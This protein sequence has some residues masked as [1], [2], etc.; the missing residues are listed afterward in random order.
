MTYCRGCGAL[1]PEG[2]KFCPECGAP[3]LKEPERIAAPQIRFPASGRRNRGKS[4]F[5]RWWF[6]VLLLAAIGSLHSRGGQDEPEPASPA[7]RQTEVRAT[8]APTARPTQKP[9]PAPTARPTQ[10][11]SPA[12]TATPTPAPAVDEQVIRPEIREFLDAYEA[13][14]NEYVTFMQKYL[15]DPMNAV[16][17]LGDYYRIL[18]R[19]IEFSDK[20]DAMDVDELTDAELRYY[21]EVTGRVNQK[22]LTVLD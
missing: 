14:M 16:S 8:A 7:L 11:P 21:L 20:I 13:C 1:V 18:D 12:P 4:L 19:Y 2:T 15:S 6:W 5:R 10:K 17:M 22:L 3:V 9:S